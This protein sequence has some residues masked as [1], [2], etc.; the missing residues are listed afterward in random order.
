VLCSPAPALRLERFGTVR[1]RGG[2]SVPGLGCGSVP[3]RSSCLVGLRRWELGNSR[4]LLAVW[5]L[6]P[7][8]R[9]VSYLGTWGGRFELFNIAALGDKCAPITCAHNVLVQL[10]V[11]TLAHILI[12]YLE[13][14]I[15]RV[16]Q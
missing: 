15:S 4:R 8:C 10:H 16:W 1:G 12:I 2:S 14:D 9:R 13:Y 5:G 6:V 11:S 7:E 3:E